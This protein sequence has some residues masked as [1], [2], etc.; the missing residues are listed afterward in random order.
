MIILSKSG[1]DTFKDRLGDLLVASLPKVIKF[2]TVVGTIAMLLVAGGILTHNVHYF[3]TLYET[4]F[5]F[6]PTMMYD[7]ILGIVVGYI[8][9]IVYELIPHRKKAE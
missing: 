2:L 4:T 6:M 3:H 5:N 8:V 9:F 1:E 7:F